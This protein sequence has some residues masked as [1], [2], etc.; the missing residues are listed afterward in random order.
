MRTPEDMKRL[1]KS[2]RY[3]PEASV[4]QR[5]LRAVD[6]V[7]D[8]R[9]VPKPK[10][11]WRVVVSHRITKLAVATAAIVVLVMALVLPFKVR[12]RNRLADLALA[13]ALYEQGN[14]EALVEVLN[15]GTLEFKRTVASYLAEIGSLETRDALL[16][17]AAKESNPLL[18]EAFKSAVDAI[19]RRLAPEASPRPNGPNEAPSPDATGALGSPNPIVLD[20]ASD[21]DPNP[22]R[23]D[24]RAAKPPHA[25]GDPNVDPNDPVQ[26]LVNIVATASSSHTANMGPENTVNGSGLDEASRQHS[27]QATDMWLSR[28]N[29]PTPWIQYEFDQVYA[30]QEMWVWN[31]NQ[32]VEPFVGLGAKDVVVEYSLDGKTWTELEGVDRFNQATGSAMYTANTIVDLAGARAKF[33]L[34]T[35]KGGFGVMPHYGLSEVQFFAR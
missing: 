8:R 25:P 7:L 18:K 10:P 13:K 24:E 4:D 29:D 6:D 31:S 14:A 15:A 28:M 3:I 23:P 30:L 11:L 1:A 27:T 35:I 2:V 20:E 5:I 21:I 9:R 26:R 22:G 34:I 16:T 32:L 12:E 33:L 19:N 17:L